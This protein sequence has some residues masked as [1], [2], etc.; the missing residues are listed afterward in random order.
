MK[1]VNIEN[2]LELKVFVNGT[3]DV[4]LMPKELFDSFIAAL[5]LQIGNYLENETIDNRR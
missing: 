1:E 3:P 2:E 5:E 4:T